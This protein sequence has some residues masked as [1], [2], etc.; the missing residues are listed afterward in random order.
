[1]TAPIQRLRAAVRRI[2]E[3]TNGRARTGILHDDA[4]G[5]VGTIATDSAIGFDPLPVLDALSRHGANVVVIG[6]VA[7]IMHG[8]TE[9]TGD[10]D[11]LWDGAAAQA[12]RLAAAFESVGA[13]ITDAD[14]HLVPCTTDSFGL[15]KVYFD[16]PTA[17]GDCCTARLPWGELDIDGIIERADIAVAPD[18]MTIRY[19]NA[20]DL[21]VMR[22]AVGRPKDLRR[23]DELVALGHVARR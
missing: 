6:Q 18:G 7:G 21:V 12:P 20:A 3:E 13:T 2:A 14:G 22:R 9:L 4:D 17:S 1:M 15:A 5:V 16:A 10:L 8:S 23:V 11:L 19:V